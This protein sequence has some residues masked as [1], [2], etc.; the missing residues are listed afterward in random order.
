[1][2]AFAQAVTGWHDFYLMVGTAGATLL[3]LLFV[4]LSINADTIARPENADLRALAEQTF[5]TFLYILAFAVLFLIPDQIAFGLGFP[6]LGV[7]GF[8]IFSTLRHFL[9]TR[10]YPTREWGRGNIAR[11]FVTP[12]ICFIVLMVIGISVLLGNTNSL[13]WLIPIMISLIAAASINAWDLLLRLR[14]LR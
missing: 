14:E 7:A 13:Y 10:P 5:S 9:K 11:R 1:M 12:L 4:S 3:G 2:D 8:G 6:L